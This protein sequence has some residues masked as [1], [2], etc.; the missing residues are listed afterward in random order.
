M[1]DIARNAQQIGH[2]LYNLRHKKNL[3]QSQLAEMAC[4]RQA[5]I[6]KIENG[7]EGVKLQTLFHLITKLNLELV[8]RPRVTHS[9]E[10]IIAIFDEET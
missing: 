9:L 10:E 5:T 1:E 4:L 7:D 2:I 8:V 6:S 3:T